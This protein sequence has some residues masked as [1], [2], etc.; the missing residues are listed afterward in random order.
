MP[1]R[2]QALFHGKDDGLK[3]DESS[4]LDA[5]H[6]KAV[7]LMLALRLHDVLRLVLTLD[8]APPSL[9]PH[10]KADSFVQGYQSAH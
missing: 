1:C 9:F 10:Q 5:H 2:T 3:A 7:L 4:D 8:P 6:H